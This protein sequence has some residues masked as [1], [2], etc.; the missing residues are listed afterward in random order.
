MITYLFTGLFALLI[1][2]FVYFNVALSPEVVNNPYNSRQENFAKR[3]VRG[4]ILSSDRGRDREAQLSLWK[5]ICP[6]S[7]L[8][9]Q[10][11]VRNRVSGQF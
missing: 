9:Y 7:G 5:C 10:R 11:T 6:C 3:V 1:G 8:F 4:S 2:Y